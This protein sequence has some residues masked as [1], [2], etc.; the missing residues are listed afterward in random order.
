MFTASIYRWLT[1]A[2]FLSGAMLWA[3]ARTWIAEPL[4][5]R[6]QLVSAVMAAGVLLVLLQV[7]VRHTSEARAGA[8]VLLTAILAGL[9]AG[10]V[11]VVALHLNLAYACMVVACTYAVLTLVRAR[12]LLPPHPLVDALA[13]AM[14]GMLCAAGISMG[15]DP[16]PAVFRAATGAVA[17]NT[18]VLGVCGPRLLRMETQGVPARRAVLLPW[19]ALL[20]GLTLACVGAVIMHV[21][22]TAPP[23]AG[24][25]E[26]PEALRAK[27][28]PEQYRCTQ[29]GGTER[30]FANAYWD[31]HAPGIYVDLVSGEPLFSSLD[32]Y[33]SGTGWPSFTKPL[34]DT[35]QQHADVS[36]GVTRTEVRSKKGQAH[37]G[38]VFDDG[39][40]PTGQRFCINSAAL[41]FVP[42]ADMHQEGYGPYLFTFAKTQGWQVATLAGGCFWGMEEIFEHHP[43]VIQT[44][45]GYAGG[46]EQAATYEQVSSGSTGHAEALQVLFDPAKLSYAQLLLFFFKVHDPTTPN[47]QGN[48]VGSQYRSAIFTAD[49]E[50]AKVAAAV[51]HQ[52]EASKQWHAPLTTQRLPLAGFWR[53]EAEHQGYIDRH[54]NAYTCHTERDLDFSAGP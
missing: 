12:G 23:A 52:V 28:T 44:Q 49:A 7:M 4:F 50:Q 26:S 16:S 17:L 25:P 47:R 18:L 20:L 13:S 15:A 37:L 34:A 19:A 2:L 32:K 8:A 36:L 1:R 43:G 24:A 54:P 10:L 27:L 5:P 30:P 31:N 11:F 29:E 21:Q 3:V 35:L 6:W 40:G 41:R 48:D 14:I 33:D 51:V 46:P 39:P 53:A 9:G 45:V 22:V 42:L 38:H